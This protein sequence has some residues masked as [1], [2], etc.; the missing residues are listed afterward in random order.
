MQEEF[1]VDNKNVIVYKDLEIEEGELLDPEGAALAELMSLGDLDMTKSSNYA[2]FLNLVD[3]DSFIDYYATQIYI[4][5]NDWWSGCN[6]DTPNN[7]LQFWRV[8][9]PALE[10]ASNPYADGKWPT[11]APVNPFPATASSESIRISSGS[12]TGDRKSVV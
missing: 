2:K 11:I 9:D 10:S 12:P 3:V 8:A 6:E 7:N 1:S 5:N 4:N